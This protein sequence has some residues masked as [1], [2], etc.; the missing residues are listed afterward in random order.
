M[1]YAPKQAVWCRPGNNLV[2]KVYSSHVLPIYISLS[3]I[4][5][6][7]RLEL[8]FSLTIFLNFLAPRSSRGAN[9][10]SINQSINQRNIFSLSKFTVFISKLKLQ[11]KLNSSVYICMCIQIQLNK[12][13]LKVHYCNVENLPIY[14]CSYKNNTLKI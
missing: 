9:N 12:H 3:L 4:G 11:C 2:Y 5:F 8:K 10:Q 1:L 14:L 13:T 7:N 6:L